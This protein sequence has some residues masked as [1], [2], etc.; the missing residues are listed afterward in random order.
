MKL[1]LR[2][3]Q[4]KPAR[5]WPTIDPQSTS[6]EPGFAAIVIVHQEEACVNFGRWDGL[7]DMF[8][9]R[10]SNQTVSSPGPRSLKPV[11]PHRPETCASI[12]ELA[13]R[14]APSS[15]PPELRV[16]GIASGIFLLEQPPS[17]ECKEANRR[18]HKNPILITALMSHVDDN[19]E[20][21]GNHHPGCKSVAA[22]FLLN[23][24]ETTLWLLSSQRPP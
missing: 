12:L 2:L 20:E 9:S 7:Q 16:I 18:H 17:A 14:S 11:S 22:A 23:I 15:I 8:L 3:L 21:N 24:K 10:A 19:F 5:R 13:K 4:L 6:S 1:R